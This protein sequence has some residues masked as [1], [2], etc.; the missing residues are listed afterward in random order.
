MDLASHRPNSWVFCVF[1]LISL[2]QVRQVTAQTELTVGENVKVFDRGLWFDGVVLG[3]NKNR[4]GVEFEFYTT[5][6]RGFF[7]RANIR[8]Q[9]EVD[10]IDLS[11]SW[12]I[13]SG[14]SKVEAALKSYTAD[15][16]ILAE[17]DDSEVEIPIASLSENDQKYLKKFKK[18]FEE[19]V[20]K[21][22][23][24]AMIPKLPPF[25]TFADGFESDIST[26]IGEG[27]IGPLGAI[28]NFLREFKHSGMG[29]QF[30]R[31]DQRITDIIPVGGPEQWVIVSAREHDVKG[32]KNFQS[33]AY[34]LSL[35]QQKVVSSAPLTPGD[36][37]VDY[38]PRSK[39]LVSV[40]CDR[41]TKE[42]DRKGSITIWNHKPA[43]SEARPFVRWKTPLIHFTGPDF[44]KLVNDHTVLVKTEDK[45]FKAFD[46]RK[47]QVLYAF[48]QDSMYNAAVVMTAD[49][50]HLLVPEDGKVTVLNAEDGQLKFSLPVKDHNVSGVN[51]DPT[52]K[53][54]VCLTGSNVYVWDLTSSDPTPTCYS[55]PSIGWRDHA[56]IEW[57]NDDLVLVHTSS[58]LTLY[59]LSLQLPVWS[60]YIDTFGIMMPSEV[61]RINQVLNGL[62]FYAV[63]PTRNRASIAIGAVELP[64]PKVEEL[65]KDK[66]SDDLLLVKKGSHVGLKMES[67][68]NS[69]QVEKWLIE[70]IEANGWVHDPNAAI[71]IHAAMDGGTTTSVSYREVGVNNKYINLTFTP[72]LANLTIKN[73]KDILWKTGAFSGVP[74][75]IRGIFK[76]FA[77]RN[78]VSPNEFFRSVII[79]NQIIDPKYSHGFG[80]SKLGLKGIEIESTSPPERNADSLDMRRKARD[81]SIK[82]LMDDFQ[83]RLKD[84]PR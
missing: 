21:G 55:A 44:V 81:E 56:S 29:F 38:D 1:A 78:E 22:E 11:R 46:F 41:V 25:E 80:V 68:S 48:K 71:Q 15:K 10:A 61:Q 32:Q 50:K 27:E 53:R 72:T 33:Q 62:F 36:F 9:S 35:K 31:S 4:Y 19:A 13:A 34:W 2:F 16:I 12:E 51:I 57:V 7:N 83:K 5:K 69:T 3:R 17:I 60:Y 52:G 74:P 49:R 20:R 82:E 67:V 18:T 65:T 73:G 42:L 14:K 63:L 40:Y 6:Q 58:H 70:K 79:P 47:N 54:L 30:T 28:P 66:I 77:D 8:K 23:T 45:T 75:E 43:E 76:K 24:P 64:G 26:V 39:L 84:S 59:R 37:I